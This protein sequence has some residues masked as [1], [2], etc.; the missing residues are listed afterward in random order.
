[1]SLGRAGPAIAKPGTNSLPA[2][3]RGRYLSSVEARALDRE[4][5]AGLLPCRAFSL[6]TSVYL[7]YYFFNLNL[8]FGRRHQ[9]D[10][11]LNTLWRGQCFLPWRRPHTTCLRGTGPLARLGQVSGN[12][13]GV[14]A[15][16]WPHPLDSS[17]TCALGFSLFV[18]RDVA[19]LVKLTPGTLVSLP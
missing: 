3:G 15:R 11:F 12:G 4:E 2:A 16:T 5:T 9:D 1:M 17:P 6:L 19:T 10:Y 18:V 13:V 7:Y 14:P 8:G